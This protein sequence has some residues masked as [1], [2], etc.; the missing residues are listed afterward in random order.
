MKRTAGRPKTLKKKEV[1][2]PFPMR[3][4]E[5]ELLMF[6]NAAGDTPVREWIRKTLLAAVQKHELKKT[7]EVLEGPGVTALRQAFPRPET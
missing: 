5:M 7:L 6:E 4:S 2:K 3:F 1:K